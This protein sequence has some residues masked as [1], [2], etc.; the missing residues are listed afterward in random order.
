MGLLLCLFAIKHVLLQVDCNVFSGFQLNEEIQN[1]LVVYK[2]E[3]HSSESHA[4][5]MYLILHLSSLSYSC[6]YLIIKYKFVKENWGFGV[7]G[8]QRY[9]HIINNQLLMKVYQ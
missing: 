8:I 5:P 1:N 7:L 3:V 2:N 9:Y 4:L 6:S